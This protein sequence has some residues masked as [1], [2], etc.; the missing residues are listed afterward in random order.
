M[1]LFNTDFDM[2][3]GHDFFPQV[4]KFITYGTNSFKKVHLQNYTHNYKNTILVISPNSQQCIIL[5]SFKFIT[6]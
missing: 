2:I 3:K 1:C 4:M 5:L 6:D